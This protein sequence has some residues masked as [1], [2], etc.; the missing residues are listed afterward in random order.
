M[1]VLAESI[2]KLKQLKVLDVRNNKL[3]TRDVSA[4]V[5]LL[6]TNKTLQEVDISSAIISKKNMLHLWMALH[7]NI[8]VCT[9][10]YSRINFM[11]LDQIMALDAELSMNCIIRDQIKPLVDTR[12]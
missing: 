11:A 6:S 2:G 4:L 10:T 8:N 7:Y 3:R 5:P 9:L 1:D 12:M